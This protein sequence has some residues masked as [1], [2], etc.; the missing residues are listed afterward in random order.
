MVKTTK[1]KA[2]TTYNMFV[3]LNRPLL[4]DGLSFAE[5]SKRLGDMWRRQ[6]PPQRAFVEKEKNKKLALKTMK[7][8]EPPVSPE[9]GEDEDDEEEEEEEDGDEEEDEDEEEEEL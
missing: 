2:T 7:K 1:T 4:P 8:P 6:T 5:K 3:T 9:Q